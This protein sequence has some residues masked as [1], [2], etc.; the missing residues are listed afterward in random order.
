MAGRHPVI[1]LALALVA[2][3]VHVAAVFAQMGSV[4]RPV[5]PRLNPFVLTGSL[6]PAAPGPG[7]T[8]E[9]AAEI[10]SRVHPHIRVVVLFWIDGQKREEQAYVIAPFAE[11]VVVHEWTADPGEHAIRI[12][13]TSPAG[14]R[15]TSWEQRVTVKGR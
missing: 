14:V 1:A 5:D 11:S 13:V 7:E 6:A 8:V 10:R 15:Y 3:A 9:I 4:D 12:D 2:L